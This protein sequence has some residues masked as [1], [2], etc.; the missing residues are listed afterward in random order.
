MNTLHAWGRLGAAALLAIL[1]MGAGVPDA[2]ASE[3]APFKITL[4]P[5]TGGDQEVDALDVRWTLDMPAGSTFDLTAPITYAG[6]EGVADRIEII[7]ARDASGP[8]P[9]TTSD[10]PPHPGGFPHFRHWK[11]ERPVAGQIEVTYLARVRSPGGRGG[12]PFDLRAS[13]GGVSGAGSGFLLLPRGAETTRSRLIWDLTDLPAGSG[14]R[15]TFGEGG[16]DIEGPPSRLMQ[17]WYMAG[18]FGHYEGARASAGFNAAWLGR[19]PF[20]AAAEMAWAADAYAYLGEAFG[21]LD[22]VPPYRVFM[23]FVDG[24]PCGGGTALGASFMYARCALTTGETAPSPRETLVHEM[25][26]MWVGGVEGPQ[27][28]TSWFSEGLTTHYTRLMMLRGGLDSVEAYGGH[29]NRSAQALYG[30]AAQDMSAQ[31]I[32]DVGF[33]DGDIRHIPYHR[34]AFYFADLDARIRERSGGTRTLDTVLRPM[35]EARQAG[36]T[37]DHAAWIALVSAEIGPQAKD[38]FEARILRGEAFAPHRGAFGP[39]FTRRDKTY[40]IAG[41]GPVE[42]YEWVRQ[43]GAS[44]D[45]CRNW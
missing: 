9:F 2:G 11:A 33:A 18:P 31:A 41:H 1:M 4:K 3:P 42:R 29:I 45:L 32:V 8:I 20:D 35:F 22:P 24:A 13:G 37:F 38:E 30:L 36:Q 26:H 23:R 17:G 39:C 12:P 19:A 28:V 7:S 10:D 6:V 15:T 14:A 27:G 16:V 25:V 43:T 34:G 5:L 44:D 21:Y 40:E